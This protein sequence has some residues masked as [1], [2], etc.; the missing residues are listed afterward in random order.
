[1]LKHLHIRN[2]AVI[3]ELEITFEPGMTVFTGETGAGKSI[4]VDALGLVLGDRADNSVIRADTDTAEITA[5]FSLSKTPEIPEKL[6][7]QGITTE[8]EEL[9]LRR[10]INRDGRSRAW[11]N[12]SPVTI[13]LLRELGEGMVDI[14]GQH[15]HQSL[16]R[17]DMQRN[18]LDAYGW[19]SDVLN[20]VREFHTEWSAADSA[21]KKLSGNDQDREARL[22]LLKFQVEELETLNVSAGEIET[23]AGE[24]TRLANASRLIESCRQTRQH[25]TEDEHSLLS[26]INRDIH[27]LQGLVQFDHSL[28]QIVELLEG[29]AVHVKEADIELRHYLDNLDLDP[30]RTQTVEDRLA[31]IHDM[32]RKHK[33]RPEELPEHLQSLRDELK[34]LEEGEQRVAELERA[35]DQALK[36]YLQAADELHTWRG[37]T[38]QKLA[39]EIETRLKDLGM[40]AARFSIDVQKIGKETPRQ[41]GMDRIEFLVTIN[42]GQELQPL[43][44]VA[45]G[46]ELSRISL[47]IQVIGSK[48]KGLPTLIFDEVD[49]GIGGAIAEIVGKLLHSL[50]ANRQ[51]FC[52]THLPQV[53]ALGD[54]HLQVNKALGEKTTVT[55]VTLL[56][57]TQ[58]VEEI[59]RMLGG[60]KITGKTREHAREM[61]KTTGETL[62][63]KREA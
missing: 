18:L 62:N 3:E 23:L 5:I 32:A 37:K 4:I 9:I 50:A 28:T 1:L 56:N 8:Q 41:E 48:D 40:P 44:K 13:Q 43:T 22:A 31:A 12:G 35:R 59:A 36:E 7:E 57:R 11:A 34:G 14:H 58:R 55:E 20:R 42:P 16:L 6:E 53:A 17:P 54:H 45:S 47:A 15:D 49:A 52:V 19:Y 21:L 39:R 60:L 61:L 63:V 29:A 38:A 25:L 33:V 46:G 26:G 24:H 51:V 10:V 27:E 30:A 2:L